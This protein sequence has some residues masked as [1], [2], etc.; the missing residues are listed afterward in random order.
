MRVVRP[1]S[2]VNVLNEDYGTGTRHRARRQRFDQGGR[3]EDS[4]SSRW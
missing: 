1:T 4:A 3:A 2:S